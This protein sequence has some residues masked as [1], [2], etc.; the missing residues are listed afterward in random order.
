MNHL[1][2]RQV[3]QGNLLVGVSSMY[4]C[5]KKHLANTCLIGIQKTLDHL[6][7]HQMTCP[8]NLLLNQM[9]LNQMLMLACRWMLDQ[10]IVRQET[11]QKM[12]SIFHSLKE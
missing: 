10:W 8:P 3:L 1:V 2:K 7:Q 6:I 5:P 12:K 11:M 4:R 9:Q